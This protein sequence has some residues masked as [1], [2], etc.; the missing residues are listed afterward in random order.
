MKFATSYFYHV[1]FFKPYM[2]P[3]STA[4]WDP[5]WFHDFKD[6]HHN[7]ID[8][9][10][11]LNGLRVREF[12]PGKECEDLCRGPETCLTADPYKCLFLKTYR[13]QLESIDT[14]KMLDYFNKVCYKAK[15]M[16]HFTEEPIAV[17]MVYEPLQKT[18]SERII[19]HDVLH[20]KG[21]DIQELKYPIQDNY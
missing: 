6:D 17:L 4:V 12:R 5:K 8:K 21:I 9:N 2:I 11:V 13:K 14:N 20:E 15:Q 18:C 3:F 10:G 19:I 16:M 7:F 1:R